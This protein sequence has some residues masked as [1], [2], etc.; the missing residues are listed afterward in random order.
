M[1]SPDSYFRSV[2][3]LGHRT[4][5]GYDLLGNP[6]TTANPL[7]FVT[8]LGYDAASRRITVQD[9]NGYVTSTAYDPLNRVQQVTDPLGFMTSNTY[10]GVGQWTRFTD[11]AYPIGN[12]TT[13]VYDQ[14]HGKSSK[15]TSLAASPVT[16]TMRPITAARGPMLAAS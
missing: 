10:D 8:T 2:D 12:F 3:P 6:T 13:F 16:R 4:T 7:G 9:A 1:G 14:A 11:A 15:S 5:Y